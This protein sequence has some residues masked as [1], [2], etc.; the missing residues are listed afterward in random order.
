MILFVLYIISLWFVNAW[1]DS[2]Y[3]KGNDAHISGAFLACLIVVGLFIPLPLINA[4]D[5]FNIA[6]VALSLRW[7]FFDVSYNILIGQK[8]YFTGSTAMLDKIPN[9]VQFSIKILLLFLC[10][11]I[12]ACYL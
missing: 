9:W 6:F 11:P 3:Y 4:W 12:I 10:V 7:I 2:D 5:Y 8:W 1:H